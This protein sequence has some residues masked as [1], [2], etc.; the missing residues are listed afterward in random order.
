MGLMTY[1]ILNWWT[2]M[3]EIRLGSKGWGVFDKD[4][5]KFVS[6][7]YRYVHQAITALNSMLKVDKK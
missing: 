4:N 3:F 2:K 1:G 5:Y 7:S 6:K